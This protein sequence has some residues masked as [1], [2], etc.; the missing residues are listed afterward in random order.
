VI[1]T[2]GGVG[3]GLV[4]LLGL[5]AA[6]PPGGQAAPPLSIRDVWMRP[7]ASVGGTTAAY[8]SI[9]NRGPAPLTIVGVTSPAATAVEMHRMRHEGAV[10]RME[11][12]ERLTIP[13][14][15][16][17]TLEPGGLH[18]MVIGVTRPLPPGARVPLRFSLDGGAAVETQA[19]VRAE[20]AR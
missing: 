19:M 1:V 8:L 13:A 2:W 6:V 16:T 20:G 12:L 10:M 11:M 5:G 9:E 17:V 3:W 18:L 15:Q 14:R 7:A 4:L